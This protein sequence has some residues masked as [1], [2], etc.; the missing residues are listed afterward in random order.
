MKLRVVKLLAAPTRTLS[1][2]IVNAP[3]ITPS[4][5]PESADHIWLRINQHQTS[6]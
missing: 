4:P 6:S 1:S 5:R 3:G 2:L